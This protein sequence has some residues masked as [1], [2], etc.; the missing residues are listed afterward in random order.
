MA[1]RQNVNNLYAMKKAAWAVLFH[2][3][4]IAKSQRDTNFAQELEL[5][6]I[7]GRV[8]K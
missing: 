3:S 7:C 8:I 5:V 6:G 4:D 1:I 2:N